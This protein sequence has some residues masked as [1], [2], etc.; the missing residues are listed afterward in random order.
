MGDK[1]ILLITGGNTGLGYEVVRAL[2]ASPQAYEILLGS[3]SPEKGTKAVQSLQA[4]FPNSASHLSM[5]QI[6]IEDQS[7]IETLFNDV[8]SKYGKLDI[9]VNNA[10]ETIPL[11]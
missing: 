8:Q 7:S 3:R 6:D 5:V 2:C 11:I 4:E 9:L 10:G 1:K